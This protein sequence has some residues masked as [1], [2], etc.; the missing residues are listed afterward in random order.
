MKQ[1]SP[2]AI[3]RLYLLLF[4]LCLLPF[5]RL[6]LAAA[7]NALRPD[8]VTLLAQATGSWSLKLLLLTLAFTPLRKLT[9][10]HWLI[11][12]RRTV[13]LFTFFYVCLHFMT[14]LVFE[15]FFDWKEIGMDILRRPYVTAG[16]LSFAL[17]VPLAVTS[18]N[19][20]MRRLGG[21]RWKTLHRLTYLVAILAVFHYFWLVKRDVTAPSIYGLVL[22]ILFAAR[23]VDRPYKETWI[24]G[25][26]EW[27]YSLART[28]ITRS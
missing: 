1:P 27:V 13:A 4:A 15:Q 16:F 22:M 6:L 14:Y 10:W 26:V 7:L 5:L 24:A 9:G 28:A 25:R 3:H 20:M 21:R 18:T 8:P 17:M 19:A 2:R 11:R 23:I 12:L